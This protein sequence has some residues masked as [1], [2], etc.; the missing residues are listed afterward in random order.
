MAFLSAGE[1]CVEIR[2]MDQVG[3][4]VFNIWDVFS[5]L[6]TGVVTLGNILEV[7]PFEDP[8][9]VIEITGGALWDALEA[10]FGKWPAQ[11]GSFCRP[12]ADDYC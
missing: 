3:L 5:T 9:V 1:L 2:N 12:F 11:E 8:V 4:F 10:A 7:L 6:K